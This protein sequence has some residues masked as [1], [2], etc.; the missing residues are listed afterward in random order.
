MERLR[1]TWAAP[2]GGGE[3]F[4]WFV[5]WGWVYCGY[6]GELD[7]SRGHE[8]YCNQWEHKTDDNSE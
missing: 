4:G 5:D 6:A 3:E 1:E 8:K 2:G 7:F